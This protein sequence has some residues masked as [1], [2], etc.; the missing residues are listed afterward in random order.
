[1]AD[2]AILLKVCSSFLRDGERLLIRVQLVDFDIG[3]H[4]WKQRVGLS[5][6]GSR[7]F[8]FYFLVSFLPCVKLSKADK[9]AF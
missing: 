2:V 4:L 8:P 9:I 1:M 7:M 6:A 5:K 3:L